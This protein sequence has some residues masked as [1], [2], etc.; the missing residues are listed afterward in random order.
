MCILHKK[1]IFLKAVTPV[2]LIEMLQ[3]LHIWPQHQAAG[4]LINGFQS[5][6]LLPSYS[7]EGC[8]I[9]ENLPSVGRNESVVAQKM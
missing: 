4:F 3:F 1:I 5:G 6:F 9:V 2:E 7:G 8:L